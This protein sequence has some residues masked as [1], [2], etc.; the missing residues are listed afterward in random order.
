VIARGV[1]TE[2]DADQ[3][4]EEPDEMTEVV[5]ETGIRETAAQFFDACETGGGWE[6]CQPYCHPEATFAAQAT[7]L[8]GVDSLEAYTEWMRGLLGP[9]PDG[10]AEVQSFAVDETRSKVVIFGVFRGTNTG[11]GGP[12]PPTGRS[13]TADYVYDMAFDHGKVRHLTKIWN[14][15]ASM[16]Q[17][18]WA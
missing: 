14:D 6:M 8:E 12:V 13:V 7:A 5:E 11:D 18:G 10:R 17:L 3:C 16:Q 2:G 1:W 9:V 4:G 15:V